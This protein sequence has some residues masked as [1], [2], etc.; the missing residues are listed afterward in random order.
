MDA[1][2]MR[3][4]L[5]NPSTA[6]TVQKRVDRTVSRARLASFRM[7]GAVHLEMLE[8]VFVLRVGDARAPEG[9]AAWKG[10]ADEPSASKEEGRREIRTGATVSK[11]ATNPMRPSALA[12]GAV[13]LVGGVTIAPWEGLHLGRGLRLAVDV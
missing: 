11:A 5:E 2:E 4:Y 1:K 8:A 10:D 3:T 7:G 12:V 13:R 6:E 9:Q